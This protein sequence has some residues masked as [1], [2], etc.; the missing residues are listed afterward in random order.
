MP[1]STPRFRATAKLV[2][3]T[4]DSAK[5]QQPLHNQ[6]AIGQ[7]G[8]KAGL[9]PFFSNWENPCTLALSHSMRSLRTTSFHLGWPLAISL[10]LHLSFFVAAPAGRISPAEP[11]VFNVNF[12]PQQPKQQIVSPTVPSLTPPTKATLRSEHDSSAEKEQIQ[13]GSGGR[14]M[15]GP[16]QPNSP[17]DPAHQRR[18]PPKAAAMPREPNLTIDQRELLGR[19]KTTPPAR[20]ERTPDPFADSSYRPFSRPFGSGAAFLTG[21]GSPDFLPHLP[22]GDIT[23]LN[24][25]AYTHAV[26]VRRVA[27]QVFSELRH[28]GWETLNLRDLRSIGEPAMVSGV[29]SLDGKVGNVTLTSQS[30]SAQFDRLLSDAVRKGLRDPNP[31]KAAAL[32]DNLIHFIFKAQSWGQPYV[33]PRTGA[34][35]ERR[36]LLLATGLE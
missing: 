8:S 15:P 21:Q 17:K 14:E 32:E 25:K 23:F 10:L 26:F 29:L 19:F 12:E 6:A 35:T 28:S 5:R 3:G 22:D 24:A 33:H 31:P 30:G 27:E 34:P 4:E 9:L 20:Q 13:R 2:G 1:P 7:H 11:V 16:R 18:S 36:W